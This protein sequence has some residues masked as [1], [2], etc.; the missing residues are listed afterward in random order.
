MIVV[1]NFEWFE[2][3]GKLKIESETNRFT[4]EIVV[5]TPD[6]ALA[7]FDRV[8]AKAPTRS[9]YAELIRADGVHEG[10]Y[11]VGR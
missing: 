9:E 6:T 11:A 7:R 4:A 10:R 2:I 3:E 5:R 1:I 8:V